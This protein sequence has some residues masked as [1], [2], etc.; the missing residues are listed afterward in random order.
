MPKKDFKIGK[1]VIYNNRKY[2]YIVVLLSGNHNINFAHNKNDINKLLKVYGRIF[3]KI[4]YFSQKNILTNQ[5]NG[6][7]I[8]PIFKIR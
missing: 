6:K 8:N 4:I 2:S 1:T 5:I 3:E 7:I